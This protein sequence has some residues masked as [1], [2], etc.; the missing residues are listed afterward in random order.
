MFVV[1]AHPTTAG[2]LASFAS[3]GDVTIAEPGA[4]IAFTGPRVV[5]QTTREKL[6]DDF[7]LA[8]QQPPLRPPRRDRPPSRAAPVPGAAP[9]ALWADEAEL[10]LRERLEPA[11]RACR[12]CA[13]RAFAARPT[14]LQRAARAARRREA[15]DEE[16]WRSVELARH[17]DRPY[18]LD[19]VERILDDWVEL[20]GDR[21]RADDGALVTGLGT[22]DGRT[23]VARRPPEGPRREGAARP[24]VRHGVPG[25]LREGDARDGARRALRLPGRL[26]RRHARR[27]SRASPPSSTA[28]A[29]RS[30]ARR[31]RWPA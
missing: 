17:Q 11:A 19:Y 26:A 28:R 15:T 10:S 25:G 1:L 23:V 6:P 18:T 16:I 24:P 12:S 30:R 22:L 31:R 4:L 8:E 14:R 5:Q 3:L 27:L 9:P 2:V 20:H 13:G 7:G 21:G 29:A